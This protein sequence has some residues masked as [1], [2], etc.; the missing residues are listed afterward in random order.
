MSACRRI[1]G[2]PKVGKSSVH[3]IEE[4][5]YRHSIGS[6]VRARLII[7]VIFYVFGCML[8]N[9]FDTLMVC[10]GPSCMLNNRYSNWSIVYNDT[11]L[12]VFVEYTL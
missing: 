10:H 8:L 7:T 1:F 3:S 4:L 11:C 2:L 5:K 6:F 12:K 9:I